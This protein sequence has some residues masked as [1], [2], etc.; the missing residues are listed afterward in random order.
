MLGSHTVGLFWSRAW[1]E[2]GFTGVRR[3]GG[4]SYSG[5]ELDV[6]GSPQGEG[7]HSMKTAVTVRMACTAHCQKNLQE[8]RFRLPGL[9]HLTEWNRAQ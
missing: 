9:L 8:R 4:G 7:K 6:A 5:A 2:G 1:G 3:G